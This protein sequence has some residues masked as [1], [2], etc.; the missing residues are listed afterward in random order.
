MC[1]TALPYSPIPGAGLPPSAEDHA[2]RWNDTAPE[3]ADV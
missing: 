3:N 1:V 2:R